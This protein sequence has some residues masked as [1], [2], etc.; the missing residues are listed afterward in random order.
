MTWLDGQLTAL[1]GFP[2]LTADDNLSLI[3]EAYLMA[4]SRLRQP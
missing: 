3:E 1:E 2:G 4:A